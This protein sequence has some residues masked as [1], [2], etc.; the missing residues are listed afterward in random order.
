MIVTEDHGYADVS[1]YEHPKEIRTPNIDRIAQRGVR[2]TQGY[3]TAYV[4]A[5][6]RAALLTGRQQQRFG[7]YTA[8]DPRA[9]MPLSE[10]T[11]AVVLKQRGY[12]TGALGKWHLGLDMEHHPMRRGFGEF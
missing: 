4:C 9:G 7:F 10:T 1:A 6:T 12:A 3:A 8:S 5:P 2:F 11:M